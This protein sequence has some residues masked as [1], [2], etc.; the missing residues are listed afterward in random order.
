M[1]FR[2]LLRQ[3]LKRQSLIV[4]ACVVGMGVGLTHWPRVF[5]L[6]ALFVFAVPAWTRAAA[7]E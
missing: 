7:R 3:R 1:T 6:L 4:G 5:W 2:N